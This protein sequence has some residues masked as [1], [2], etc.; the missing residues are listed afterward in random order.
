MHSGAEAVMVGTA[1]L[2]ADESGAFAVH[3]AAIADPGRGDTVVTRASTGSPGSGVA[4]H[5]HRQP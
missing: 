2:R 4:Q 5:L 1:L 3:K